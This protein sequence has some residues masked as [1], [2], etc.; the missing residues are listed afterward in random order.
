MRVFVNSCWLSSTGAKWEKES[1]RVRQEWL[2]IGDSS[3]QLSQKIWGHSKVD[4]RAWGFQVKQEQEFELFSTLILIWPGLNN[5]ITYLPWEQS[6]DMSIATSL[7]CCGNLGNNWIILS[8]S[9]SNVCPDGPTRSS[10]RSIRIR[11]P[12]LLEL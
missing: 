12:R 11:D 5:S 3:H 7:A 2:K 9:V 10:V 6:G 1:S 8:A 4:E